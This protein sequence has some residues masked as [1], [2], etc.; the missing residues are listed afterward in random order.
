[1]RC[2]YHSTNSNV[3]AEYKWLLV[4]ELWE[5]MAGSHWDPIIAW[6]LLQRNSGKTSYK[7]GRDHPITTP[8]KILWFRCGELWYQANFGCFYG[9][10][11]TNQYQR[12]MYGNTCTYA[13]CGM[14]DSWRHSLVECSM[15]RCV[16]ELVDP[17]LLNAR[18]W[19]FS[20]IDVLP[21]D[22]FIPLVVRRWAIWTARR[23]LLHEGI[24]QSHLA[25]QLFVTRF[26]HELKQLKELVQVRTVAPAAAER[27][28]WLPPQPRHFKM[29]VDAGMARA[30]TLGTV[31]IVCRDERGTYLGSSS[32]MI[33]GLSD[34][35]TL[36][37]IACRVAL[38]LAS[39]LGVQSL[40]IAPD[41][42]SV[43]KDI[44]E[45]TAVV[46]GVVIKEIRDWMNYVISFNFVFE[47]RIC[48]IEAHNLARLSLSLSLQTKG[49]PHDPN[50]IHVI[51]STE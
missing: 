28:R 19:I 29:N 2:L 24:S 44:H 45:G 21:H 39:D 31:C 8:W 27:R 32:H 36:E 46:H 11:L 41:C 20:M 25:T 10:L 9:D 7:K 15:A 22:V 17:E 33:H 3:H 30:S 51:L 18:N 35:T 43:I 12:R 5:E 47:S 1:M 50:T 38:A 40:H 37:A 13:I 26:I 42:K 34:P 14:N 48:N 6:L 23:K 49:Q 16:W 4:M